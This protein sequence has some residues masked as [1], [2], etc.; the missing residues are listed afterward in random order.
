MSCKSFGQVASELTFV[1]MDYSVQALDICH[2][3]S[4]KLQHERFLVHRTTYSSTILSD[5]PV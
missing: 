5:H 3:V 1:L 4:R 2:I